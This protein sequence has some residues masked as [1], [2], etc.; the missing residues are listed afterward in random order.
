HGGGALTAILSLA[1]SSDTIT[2]SGGFP[3]PETFPVAVL[4]DVLADLLENDAGGALQY[5]PTEGL[6]SSRLAIADLVEAGQGIRAEPDG[7]LVTS[8]GIEA[9]QLLARV[10]LEPGDRVVVEAPSYLGALMAFTGSEARVTGVAMDGEGLV[11]D[12]LEA[13]LSTGVRPKLA[14][15]IPDHQNPTGLSLSI[16]RRQALVECCR[17]YGVLLVEDVAYRDLG[18]DGKP[19]PSLWSLGPD[20]VLQ[21]GT[22]SKILFPGI[23]LGW[24]IGPRVVVDAMAAAKQNSDQCAGALGQRIMERFVAGDH[25]PAHLTEARAL[26]ARRAEKMLGALEHHMPREISWTTQAGGFFVWLTA[27]PHTDA[28]G[29]TAGARLL[30]VAY[31]PGAPFYVDGRGKNQMRLSYSRVRESDIDEGVARLAKLLQDELRRTP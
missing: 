6:A 9:L 5:S 20:V 19:L 7:V 23:R 15:V 16:Q 25:F 22:F 29:L 21:I 13:I 4:S 12:D 11:V 1:G 14:Y 28:T 8:G 10:F 2:F 18:F 17:R 31:V 27:G 26:Y 3:A 30:D 24:A